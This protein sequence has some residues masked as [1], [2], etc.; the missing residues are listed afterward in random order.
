MSKFDECLERYHK[1]FTTVLNEKNYDKELL[2]KV[3]RGLG[4][5]IYNPDSSKVSTSDQAELDRVKKNFLIKK[6]GMADAPELDAAINE[7]GEWFGK[8]NRNKFRAI[9]Y[10][11]LVQK[12]N[13]ASVYN[14]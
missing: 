2:T 1:E 10:Y 14:K 6:L 11:K 3:T 5:S 9:F 4:P 8:S 12:F 13:K 7:V